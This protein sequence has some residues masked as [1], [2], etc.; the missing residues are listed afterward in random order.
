MNINPYLNEKGSDESLNENE[1]LLHVSALPEEFNEEPDNVPPFNNAI[2]KYKLNNAKT[3]TKKGNSKF[4]KSSAMG[5]RTNKIKGMKSSYNINGMWETQTHFNPKK[6]LTLY[7]QTGKRWCKIGSRQSKRHQSENYV[8]RRNSN[9]QNK[10]GNDGYPY[11]GQNNKF[12]NLN[13]KPRQLPQLGQQSSEKRVSSKANCQIG[14]P[15]NNSSVKYNKENSKVPSSAFRAKTGSIKHSDEGFIPPRAQKFNRFLGEQIR[16]EINQ[17]KVESEQLNPNV[18]ESQ[19]LL[20]Y[21][22][23]QGARQFNFGMGGNNTRL[24]TGGEFR[25]TGMQGA[26]LIDINKI[27]TEEMEDKSKRRPITS[28]FRTGDRLPSRASKTRERIKR[29]QIGGR[30]TKKQQQGK[31]NKHIVIKNNR[32]EIKQNDVK[33]VS[34]YEFSHWV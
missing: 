12:V 25:R 4:Y 26:K 33:A 30:K 29:I 5:K 20:F 18:D 16:I 31:A 21:D 11:Y 1:K 10:Y 7:D 17:Q 15:Q 14:F 6:R 3:H 2:N 23:N 27:E 32:L 9:N 34:Y 24:A 28:H 22:F 8:D 13:H 19:S